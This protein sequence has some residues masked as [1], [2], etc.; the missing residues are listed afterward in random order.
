MINYNNLITKFI[1]N[2]FFILLII[3]IILIIFFLYYY[4]YMKGKISR[5]VV[6]DLD[7]TIGCFQQLGIFCDALERFNKTKLTRK[8]FM[9]ILDLYPEYFRPNLFNIMK[10]LK[11]KKTKGN[12]QK[13]VLYT[14][15]NGP[16]EWAKRICL[17]IDKKLDY[18]LF[19]NHIGAYKVNGQ[20]IE[21]MRTTHE[22]TIEDFF[23]TTRF[24][25]T[26]EV[27]FI[28]DLYHDKMDGDNV[29]YIHVE[30]YKIALPDKVLIDRYYTKYLSKYS[31]EK[32][33]K[34]ISDFLK[35]YNLSDLKT[36]A[37]DDDYNGKL[38][39]SH[40]QIFLQSTK[41]SSRKNKRNNYNN[42]NITYKK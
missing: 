6:F 40:L 25:K 9:D 36:D 14:N 1:N 3:I 13:I 38:I 42:K 18:K 21:M 24:S 11:E 31:Y 16:K 41:R 22:K 35:I 34:T 39:L 8:E 5:I 29:Y 4:Y 27:C 33:Y 10:F 26:S 37:I 19:D 17:Y 2:Y 32:F 28:D 20:Q 15:N 30:P 7:E 23:R 12:L